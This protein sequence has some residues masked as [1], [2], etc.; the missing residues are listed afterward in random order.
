MSLPVRIPW[1]DVLPGDVV[2][3]DGV[4]VEVIAVDAGGTVTL[5]DGRSGRPNPRSWVEVH[6]PEPAE[7][8]DTVRE[9]LGATV[10]AVQDDGK[11][12]RCPPLARLAAEPE[13]LE[14]HLSVFHAPDAVGH[15]PGS[16][17]IPHAH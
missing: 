4:P 13:R 5:A 10:L 8:L 17:S 12:Y 3:R 6:C 16:A 1:R 11:P 9:V 2:I 15:E 14:H 7:A